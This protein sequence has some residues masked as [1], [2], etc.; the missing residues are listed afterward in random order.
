MPYQTQSQ[1]REY[2]EYLAC[3]MLCE[4]GYIE[5]GCFFFA[6]EAVKLRGYWDFIIAQSIDVDHHDEDD[7]GY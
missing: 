4:D 1:P 3:D 5:Q 6:Y 7:F 2:S